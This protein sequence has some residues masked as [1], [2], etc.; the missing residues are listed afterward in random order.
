M[1]EINSLTF[2]VTVAWKLKVKVNFTYMRV[3]RIKPKW[4]IL[5][6]IVA[7]GPH[8]RRLN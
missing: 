2:T 7:L 4:L 8:G 3:T 1:L 5:C 6:T